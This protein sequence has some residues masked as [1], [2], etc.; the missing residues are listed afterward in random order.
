MSKST[1]GI[2]NA[3]TASLTAN[4]LREQEERNKRRKMEG[5]KNLDSLFSTKAAGPGKN[6]DFMS[7][8]F[9]IPAHQKQ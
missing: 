2:K 8:G 5:N 6:T 9:A 3:A 4:V 1:N 7:R